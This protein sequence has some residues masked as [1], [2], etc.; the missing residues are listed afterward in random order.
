MFD[1]L[2]LLFIF[3]LNE[4]KYFLSKKSEQG[5]GWTTDPPC[6]ELIEVK[7]CLKMGS[8]ITLGYI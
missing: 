8:T 3:A 4:K 6:S 5:K 1:R 7:S 2:I